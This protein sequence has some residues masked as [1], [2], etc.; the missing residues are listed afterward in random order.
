MENVLPRI[1]EILIDKLNL[2]PSQV[3]LEANFI[4]DLG[5]DSL[6][7]VELIMDFEQVFDIRIADTEGESLKTVG[8][9]VRLIQGKLAEK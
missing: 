2:A 3:T 5:I 1:T 4:K 7:Y 6:D 9:A 8:D